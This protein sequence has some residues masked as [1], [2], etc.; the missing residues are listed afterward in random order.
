MH[1]LEMI[2]TGFLVLLLLAVFV[3]VFGPSILELVVDKIEEWDDILDSLKEE[4]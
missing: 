4:K 2:L 3:F 1:A